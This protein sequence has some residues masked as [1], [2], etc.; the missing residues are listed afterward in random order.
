MILKQIR[1]DFFLN[2]KQKTV[3][4][5]LE[6]N[7]EVKRDEIILQGKLG[8]FCIET[9]G[10]KAG[11]GC[12]GLGI[13]TTMSELEKMGILDE[14]WD[15]IVYDVLGDVVCGGFAIPMRKHYVDKICVV[16]SADYMSLYAANNILNGIKNYQSDKN[17]LVGILIGN[18]IVSEIE[19][20]IISSF[21]EQTN[22]EIAAL[23]KD[24][25]S[26]KVSDF[27]RK[28]VLE[29]GKF[30]DTK[31]EILE[32]AVKINNIDSIKELLPLSDEKLEE[33]REDI[34]RRMLG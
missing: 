34:C 22:I 10:P 11:I 19:E 23:I 25:F 1:Q 24:S 21:A 7:G 18:K 14:D 17:P 12:A 26:F 20:A 8:I 2:K 30:L 13:S 9:G 27:E 16:T 15:A 32:L 3:L 31:G 28:L 4:E 6:K 33:F 29:S 5:I